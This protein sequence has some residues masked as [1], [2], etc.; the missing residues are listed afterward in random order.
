MTETATGDH[1]VEDSSVLKLVR[2]PAWEAKYKL[3]KNP[4]ELAHLVCCRDLDWRQA[5]CGYVEEEPTIMTE[6]ET[7]CT[8][9]VETAEKMGGL[10][11]LRQCPV[12]NQECPPEEE[13]D[14]MIAERASR[15]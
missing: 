7:L 1:A 4:E 15:T 6:V 9:C 8:M 3:S 12:D 5:L 14:R 2:V 11:G 10:M 13:V